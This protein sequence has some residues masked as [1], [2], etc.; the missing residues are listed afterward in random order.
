MR[1]YMVS[2]CSHL[3]DSSYRDEFVM[4]LRVLETKVILLFEYAIRL[5]FSSYV[6]CTGI[7]VIFVRLCNTE[8]S[9]LLF[10]RRVVAQ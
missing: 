9:G 4:C 5:L 2:G 3:S 1:S 6:H 7:L 10:A 8:R